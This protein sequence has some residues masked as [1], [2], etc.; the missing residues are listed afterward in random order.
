[1]WI[2]ASVL[3]AKG[4]NRAASPA[5]HIFGG[6]PERPPYNRAMDRADI[7]QG[8]LENNRALFGLWAAV[9]AADDRGGGPG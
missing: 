5:C 1:M 3:V 6:D 8:R 9:L 2:F 4:V 7:N